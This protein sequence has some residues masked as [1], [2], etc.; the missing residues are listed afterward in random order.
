MDTRL[1]ARYCLRETLGLAS[2]GVALFWAAGRLDWWAAWVTL[3]LNL[4]WVA[5]TAAVILRHNP[6][7][8]TE[9]LGPRKGAKP[10]DLA[11]L[12]A[13]GL[14]QL[15]R[16]IVAG[17]DLRYGWT[18]GFPWVIQAL[19]LLLSVAGYG[20]FVWAIG[21][22]A[23]FSQIARIQDERGQVVVSNGPYRLV[24]HPGYSGA[25]LCELAVPLLLASGWALLIGGI[26]AGLLVLRTALEDRL[27]LAE[28]PGYREYAQRVRFRLI[29]GVY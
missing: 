25:L 7:L 11:I 15:A 22:N 9:R 2:M 13:L 10:W 26:C 20:L 4:G 16:Y 27:L 12:G 21:S 17:L 3:G 1:V 28:L 18:G 14:L 23:F 6:G 5:A 8:L 24:R 19:A 29:P